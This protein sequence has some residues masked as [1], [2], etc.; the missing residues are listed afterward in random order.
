MK[1]EKKIGHIA[2]LPT[3]VMLPN[4]ANMNISGFSPCKLSCDCYQDG[5]CNSTNTLHTAML[6]IPS[7]QNLPGLKYM[8][9]MHTYRLHIKDFTEN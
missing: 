3:Y 4:R 2:H 1:S 5:L 9:I 6:C 8:I 7:I